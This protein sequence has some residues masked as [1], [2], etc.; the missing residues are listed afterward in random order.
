[1]TDDA[2]RK[3]LLAPNFDL[4]GKDGEGARVFSYTEIKGIRPGYIYQ[5]GEDS[6]EVPE[7]PYRATWVT[8]KG[9]A[10]APESEISGTGPV[11]L[12]F[13][14]PEE[15]KLPLVRVHSGCMTG[16]TFGAFTCD[17]GPQL[18]EAIKIMMER[19]GGSAVIYL[20]HHEGRGVGIAN[21]LE[22]YEK[23]KTEHLDTYEV[24]RQLGHE[25]DSRQYEEAAQMLSLIGLNR[26]EL[27]TGNP[28]K[29]AGLMKYGDKYGLEADKITPTMLY[30]TKEN[31]AYLSGKE[32]H[33]DH[34]F[35]GDTVGGKA[36]GGLA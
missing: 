34:E 14:T 11:A 22:A 7:V 2:Q 30:K 6:H 27:L 26:F 21:K 23:A 15:G 4:S 29:L 5:S 24:M 10:N 1:M 9:L 32:A 31:T 33:G 13:G 8:F 17:C 16:D 25:P 18:T 20:P 12:V 28:K 35:N 19:K 36:P 3:P